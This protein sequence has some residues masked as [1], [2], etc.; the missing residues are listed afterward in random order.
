MWQA[1]GVREM[2]RYTG[3]EPDWN[4]CTRPELLTPVGMGVSS[5]SHRVHRN[6]TSSFRAKIEK[7]K[8]KRKR[9]GVFFCKSWPHKAMSGWR[10]GGRSG[11]SSAAGSNVLPFLLSKVG[12]NKRQEIMLEIRLLSSNT[13][14]CWNSFFSS[15]S[16]SILEQGRPNFTI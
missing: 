7:R 13:L 3:M 14:L 11:S 2:S 15:Q 5:K 8:R 9:Y 4:S 6:L 10:W 16:I 1:R 12:K